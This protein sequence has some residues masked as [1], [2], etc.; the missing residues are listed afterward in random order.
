MIDIHL[1]YHIPFDIK[2]IPNLSRNKSKFSI[3]G[4]VFV[5][6]LD[7]KCFG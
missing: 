4:G 6:L 1:D 2:A 3:F 5:M 7:N